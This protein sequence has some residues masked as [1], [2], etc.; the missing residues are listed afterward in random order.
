MDR[1]QKRVRQ[2]KLCRIGG[3]N[4]GGTG[5]TLQ[6]ELTAATM[7]AVEAARSRHRPACANDPDLCIAEAR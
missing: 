7:I 2:Q 6:Q 4:G 3:H 5:W 1:T